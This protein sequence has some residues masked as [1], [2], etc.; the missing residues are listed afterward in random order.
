MKKVFVCFFVVCICFNVE[1]QWS[2]KSGI[3]SLYNSETEIQKLLLENKL[4]KANMTAQDFNVAGMYF[5]EKQ[6]WLEAIIMFHKA[7]LLDGSHILA[8][9]N[10]AC[11][12]SIYFSKANSGATE[13]TFA[14]FYPPLYPNSL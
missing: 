3:L 5:Y 12:L 2:N 7:L 14:L 1:A 13:K 4:Y 6:L 10:L 11:V 9:Y 8:N